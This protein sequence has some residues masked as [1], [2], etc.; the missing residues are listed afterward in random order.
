MPSPSEAPDTSAYTSQGGMTKATGKG[1]GKAK[2]GMTMAT[3]K[4]KDKG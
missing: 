1:T 3:G 4:G 2:G